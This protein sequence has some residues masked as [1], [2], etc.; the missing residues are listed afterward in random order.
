[1]TKLLKY[2]KGNRIIAVL[3]PLF[4]MLEATLELIVPLI[5][6][7]IVDSGIIPKNKD[8]VI[9]LSIQLIILGAVG[10]VFSITAQYFAAKTAVSTVKKL[11]HAAYE[12]VNSLSFSGLDKAGTSTLIT[13]LTSDMDSV[14][15]GINLTLR[16]LLRSPFVVLGACIMA[17]RVDRHTSLIFFI[18][19]PV[20]SLIIFAVMAVTIP[21]Y[22]KIRETVDSSLLLVRENITGVRVIRAFCSEEK[23][24]EEFKENND[25]LTGMQLFTGRIS[26]L[27][28]PMTC[29]IVNLAIAALIYTGAV[30]VNKGLLTTGA[31]IALY[32]Y[33]SQ[34]LVELIKL[35]NLI[36]TVT[37]SFACGKRINALLEMRDEENEAAHANNEKSNSYIEFR[38]VSFSYSG[39]SE[40]SVSDIS[41]TVNKGDRIG[42][43]GSTGSGKTT[44]INLLC[45]Y[46]QPTRGTVFFKGIPLRDYD[47]KE[48]RNCFALAEQ[49]AVIFKG[50]VKS[51]LLLGKK[52]A[53]DEEIN[54]ALEIA[55]SADF[56]N[57]KEN[58][59][60]SITE[61]SGRNFSG[62]QRQ[63]LSIARAV[64]KNAE[65]LILDDAFSALDYATE[66]QLKKELDKHCDATQFIVSQRAGFIINCDKIIVLED[67]LAEIGTHDELLE[68]SS[69]Y[70]EIYCA[71][72][73]QEGVV[74][75]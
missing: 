73:E 29:V 26:A 66:A 2:M 31:V 45:G 22:K 9:K 67:G 46:Y 28:N 50:T 8:Y 58:G 63:R 74:N 48:L 18:A 11:R 21:L 70:K 72:F 57:E 6:A 44:L 53:S 3:A 25:I 5:I 71:Q 34:I 42:I 40:N 33:L 68:K 10:L 49:K 62:G 13:R 36:V 69:V 12:K 56:V 41:F 4:K 75:A 59:T 7:E 54:K 35:A 1:M 43:I 61:Q 19:V 65:V 17:F 39:N 16:L 14:Q 15:N 64:I 60:D 38:N 32:N 55:Q 51:N 30:R 24:V 47:E 52:D 27:L 23:A 37:K 20:L